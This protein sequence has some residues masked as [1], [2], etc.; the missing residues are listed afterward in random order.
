MRAL[1]QADPDAEAQGLGIPR[2]DLGIA[3]MTPARDDDLCRSWSGGGDRGE[4]GDR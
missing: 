1:A 3:S 2:T 4:L